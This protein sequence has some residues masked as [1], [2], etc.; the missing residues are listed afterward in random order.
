MQQMN[1]S[2]SDC[3]AQK[4][5][6]IQSDA[7]GQITLSV[8]AVIDRWISMAGTA[9]SDYPAHSMISDIWGVTPGDVVEHA[10]QYGLVEITLGSNRV[11]R[12]A[13]WPVTHDFVCGIDQVVAAVAQQDQVPGITEPG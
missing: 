10:R 8:S 2:R 7:E 13:A 11:A 6:V 5:V 1:A 3:S 12:S 9:D 4:A